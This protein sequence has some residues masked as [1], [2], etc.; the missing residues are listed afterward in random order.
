MKISVIV[1]T[2]KPQTYLWECLDS[3]Y[4]QT[5]QKS[6]FE[7]ILVL[8]GCCEPYN[9]QINEWLSKHSDLQVQYFQTDEGGVS[10]ARNIALDNVRGEYVTFIDDDDLI[11]PA[12]LEELYD[13]ATPD[14]VSLC[15]PFAFND[16]QIG[17]Q[18]PYSITYTYN[19]CIEH[20][21][22]NFTSRARKFFSGP[23]MKLI[24]MSFIQ[25]RRYDIR[26]KNGEDSLFMFLISDKMKR[27]AF[28]SINAVYYRRV[29]IN[30]ASTANR[31]FK[32]VLENS[33]KLII[34]YSN[35][36]ISHMHSYD[37]FFYITRVLGSVKAVVKYK[38]FMVNPHGTTLVNFSKN[39]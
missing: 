10:N 3:I 35:I 1:P 33:Y 13:K 11:S 14:T 38:N 32:D 39:L 31:R 27:V 8:N 34:G 4:N 30:S 7:L 12:Y 21:C 19:Y 26:F 29:R 20:K 2:Y 37:F 24:P 28:T 6:D 22:R 5:F 17:E 9:T 23:C 25:N 18:L 15:Y 16:G 36:Y